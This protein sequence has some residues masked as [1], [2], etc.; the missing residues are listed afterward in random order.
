MVVVEHGRTFGMAFDCV[1]L[2]QP[3][4]AEARCEAELRLVGESL[5][6]EPEVSAQ[7]AE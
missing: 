4:P 7:V 2:Q 5:Q 3:Q 1:K 6:E